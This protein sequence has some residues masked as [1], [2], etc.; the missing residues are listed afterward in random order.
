MTNIPVSRLLQVFAWVFLCSL[1]G[2]DNE[3]APDCLKSAGPPV[4]KEYTVPTFDYIIVS[5]NVELHL[6]PVKNQRVLVEAGENLI[7]E[8][9]VTMHGDSLLIS[10]GNSCN[11]ARSYQN[12]VRV[13]V[14]AALENLTVVNRG[15]AD[16]VTDDTLRIPNVAFYSLDGGG[17]FNVQLQAGTVY[18]YSNCHSL[19]TCAGRAENFSTWMHG[20]VGRVHAEQLRAGL[21]NVRHQGSNEIRVFPVNWLNVEIIENGNVAYYHQPD[22]IASA[23]RGSGKLIRR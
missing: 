10:N 6:Q 1:P 13:T 14:G 11:W 22:S 21:C 7:G 23:I 16:V 17:N 4:T 9:N 8:I 2:C 20:G 15:Y 12:S 5:D 18:A 19:V 3:H